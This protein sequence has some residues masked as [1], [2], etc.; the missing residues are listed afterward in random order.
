MTGTV[1]YYAD[2]A[3]LSD[4]ALYD[5][6]KET[7]PKFRADKLD[8]FKFEE[9]KFHHVASWVLLAEAVENLGEDPDQME[10]AFGENGKPYFANSGIRF[11]ISHSHGR[12]MCAVSSDD[13]GCDTEKIANMNN[14]AAKRFL[15]TYEYRSL[16]ST[17]DNEECNLLFYRYWTLKESFMKATGLG[18]A[19][20]LNAFCILFE[21]GIRVKQKVDDREYHFKE[22][23]IGDGYC[24]SVC[25]VDP[26]I[27]DS[28]IRVDLS[29]K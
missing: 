5:K 6:L 26:D 27:A 10:I 23:D 19:L 11:N 14:V 16:Q 13:V 28:M 22:Y 2:T 17:E 1:V 7:L 24:Y 3:P 29:Q 12:V 25:S 8:G 20:P 9:G 4:G 15:H 21:N 18:M